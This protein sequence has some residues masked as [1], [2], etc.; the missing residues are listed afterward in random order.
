MADFHLI[1]SFW[2]F[3]YRQSLQ[4]LISFIGIY[5]I[6]FHL[7]FQFNKKDSIGIFVIS[8]FNFTSI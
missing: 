2:F 8:G 6:L 7:I 3:C 4:F 5:L 1:L